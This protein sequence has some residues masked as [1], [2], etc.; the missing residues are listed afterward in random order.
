MP[1]IIYKNKEGKR[2][3]GVTTI[4]SGNLGWNSRSLMHWAWQQGIDGIDY[5]D[6]T[7]KACD[8]GT[9]A[10]QMIEND[11][12]GVSQNFVA[13]NEIL[14]K[15]TIAYQAWCDWKDLVSF[16]LLESEKSLI[17][18]KYQ[19]GGT[20]DIVA[21][22]GVP[23]ILDLKTSKGVYPE[24]KIQ[25][26]AYGQLWNENYPDKPIQAYY[27]LQLG[28]IDG[29]FH[30]HYWPTLDQEWEAFVCL[31]KLHDLKKKIS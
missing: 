24:H 26:A 4:I 31:K 8:A 20:I 17:S 3:P 16:E 25:I 2:L 23:C 12:I 27:L 6:T 18:E 13:S 7:K 21:I 10:H 14:D 30:H 19:F 1:M 29:S 11:L 28:K 5:K 9:I 15:A 22:Q